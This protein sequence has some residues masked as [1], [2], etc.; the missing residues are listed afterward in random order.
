MD[1][2]A[3]VPSPHVREASAEEMALSQLPL[4]GIPQSLDFRKDR[5]AQ[6]LLASNGGECPA[7]Q[8]T[9]I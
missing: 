7:S 8:T 9:R 1:A 6:S 2:R 4:C 3:T 5:C